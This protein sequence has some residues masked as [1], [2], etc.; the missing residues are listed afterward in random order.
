MA[1]LSRDQGL[2]AE[3]VENLRSITSQ[4]KTFELE[5]QCQLL[6][7]GTELCERSTE[8]AGTSPCSCKCSW[9]K[10]RQSAVEG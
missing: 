1:V 3:C 5:L 7:I 9:R 8:Q 4:E 10:L 2:A 6:H